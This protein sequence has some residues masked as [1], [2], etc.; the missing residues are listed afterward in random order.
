MPAGGE[1]RPPCAVGQVELFEDVG[2]CVKSVSRTV[3]GEQL[4]PADDRRNCSTK[5]DR[6]VG[7]S[8][9]RMRLEEAFKLRFSPFSP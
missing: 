7:G 5:A 9:A 3:W 4:L 2:E 6:G 1:R 8:R